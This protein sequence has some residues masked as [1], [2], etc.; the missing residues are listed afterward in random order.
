MITTS[1]IAAFALAGFL[2]SS[3]PP[4][5]VDLKMI[6]PD[7]VQRIDQLWLVTFIND[8]GVETV[9]QAKAT[10]GDYVPLIAADAARLKSILPAAR[11]VAKANSK[12]L[13]LITF[14]R[15]LDVEEIQP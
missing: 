9:A 10:T 11:L 8:A 7:G 4:Q 14:T 5:Y 12:K 13:R 6:S 15:R 3:T 1:R 2:G